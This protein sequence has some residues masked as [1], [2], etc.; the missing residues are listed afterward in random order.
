MTSSRRTCRT[1]GFSLVE[2]VIATA[3]V[4][5]LLVAA[6]TA[7][8]ATARARQVTADGEK[9]LLLAKDLLDEVIAKPYF[10]PQGSGTLGREAGET[11]RVSFDDIDDYEGLIDNPP[12]TPDARSATAQ[13]GWKREVVVRWASMANIQNDAIADEGIKRV[14]VHVSRRGRPIR[15]LVALRTSAWDQL[16]EAR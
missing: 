8:G 6:M 2:A 14:E 11:T 12:S 7:V 1:A 15:T 13:V 9:A 5:G 16:M 10:D 4:G 3:I